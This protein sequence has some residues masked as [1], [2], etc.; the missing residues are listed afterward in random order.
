MNLDDSSSSP[1]YYIC[2]KHLLQKGRGGGHMLKI[3][4][5]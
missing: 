4:Q 3:D 1:F 2:K 5:K